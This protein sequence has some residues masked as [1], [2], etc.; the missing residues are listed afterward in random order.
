MSEDKSRNGNPPLRQRPDP[1]QV[2]RELTPELLASQ[3]AALEAWESGRGKRRHCISML[4][5]PFIGQFVPP[6]EKVRE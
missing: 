6:K 5:E 1:F 3:K 2:E 4:I